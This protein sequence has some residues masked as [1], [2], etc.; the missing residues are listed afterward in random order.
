MPRNTAFHSQ[1]HEPFRAQEFLE[2]QQ[3]RVTGPF[4]FLNPTR[5]AFRHDPAEQK[6]LSTANEPQKGA[7]GNHTSEEKAGKRDDEQLASNI[8]FKWRSRDNRKGRHTLVVDP[9]VDPSAPYLVPKQ[10][11]AAREV[12]RN[13][14]RMGT[15]IPYWDVSY[16][17]AIIFTLGSVVWVINAFFV[18]L[19]L[20]QPKTEFNDEILTGGGVSAFIGATIFEM[21]S[22]LLLV[23]AVNENRSGCFGWALTRALSGGEYGDKIRVRPDKD[24]CTHHHTNKGNF[25]GKGSGESSDLCAQIRHAY[26]S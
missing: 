4:S 15:Y 19:P 8:E 16:V 12:A 6:T 9:S 7:D 25:V 20:V 13:I 2:L 18:F 5:A 1:A 3:D 17:V 24:R 26:F 21:G 22:V 11:S 14:V 23:E 10:T